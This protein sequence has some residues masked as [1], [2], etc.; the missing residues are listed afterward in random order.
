MAP[1]ATRMRSARTSRNSAARDCGM[2]AP[3]FLQRPTKTRL[4]RRARR[5][6]PSPS[7]ER[8]GASLPAAFNQV[9]GPLAARQKTLEEALQFA[10]VVFEPSRRY[11]FQSVVDNLFGKVADA[12]QPRLKIPQAANRPVN[13]RP[14]VKPLNRRVRQLPVRSFEYITI[15]HHLGDKTQVEGAVL[16]AAE[17]GTIGAEAGAEKDG[18]AGVGVS[19]P[20]VENQNSEEILQIFHFR[21]QGV[22][23]KVVDRRAGRIARKT[24]AKMPAWMGGE[25]EASKLHEDVWIGSQKLLGNANHGD[26]GTG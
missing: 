6:L 25:T 10:A 24:G 21:Q 12:L 7:W 11:L 23:Q 13:Q 18:L 14:E 1:S 2:T 15:V 16:G 22:R 17:A 8:I 3:M 4:N 5:R 26:R 20:L 19:D 9:R